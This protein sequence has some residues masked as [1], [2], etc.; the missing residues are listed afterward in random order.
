MSV[1]FR[2]Q[3][4]GDYDFDFGE[5]EKPFLIKKTG[6]DGEEQRK[7]RWEQR[8]MAK[9][10]DCEMAVIRWFDREKRNYFRIKSSRF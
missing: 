2:R 5:D 8:E 3:S 9:T 1:E 4:I 7:R 10:V 6:K